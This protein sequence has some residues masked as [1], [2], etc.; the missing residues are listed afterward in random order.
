[1]ATR[2]QLEEQH[3]QA[4]V[5]LAEVDVQLA[6]G[7][8]DQATADRMRA[9][10]RKEL[11]TIA[12]QLAGSPEEEPTGRSLSRT[13]MGTALMI[14]ATIGVVFLVAEAVD[15]REAGEFATGSIE[16]RDLTDVTTEEM[17]RVVAEFPGVVDMR[18]ALARRYF[19][20]GD[21]SAALPHYLVIL[22]TQP[23]NPEANANVGWMTYLSDPAQAAVAATFLE[24]ALD[25]VPDYR[26]ATFFLANVRLYGLND[27]GGARPL[28]ES[29]ADAGDLPEDIAGLVA[30][31]LAETEGAL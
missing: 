1:M 5:D 10:Y 9:R 13:L 20:A 22:E 25:S 12:A 28:L 18:L 2:R 4:A 29:L 3:A 14:V 7:E 17:E 23:A 16:G 27:P 26:Q 21:F 19:D 15:E 6:S 8:F 11:E 30:E 24:R 31:L